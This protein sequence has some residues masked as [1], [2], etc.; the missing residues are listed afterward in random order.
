MTILLAGWLFRVDRAIVS[1]DFLHFLF[2]ATGSMAWSKRPCAKEQGQTQLT[3]D[4]PPAWEGKSCF[5]MPI[6]V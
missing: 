1:P 4:S 6:N 3:N 5:D 2:F